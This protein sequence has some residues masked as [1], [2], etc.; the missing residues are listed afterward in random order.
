MNDHAIKL[1]LKGDLLDAPVLPH[2]GYADVDL[3]FNGISFTQ[4][5]SD[6]IRERVVIEIL[7]VNTQEK[8]VTAENVAQLTDLIAFRLSNLLDPV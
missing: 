7:L 3:T 4:I 2:S 1:I 6:D 8:F 5:E